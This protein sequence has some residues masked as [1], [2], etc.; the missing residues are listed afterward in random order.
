MYE[1]QID[2]AF[3]FYKNKRHKILIVFND[4]KS[5]HNKIELFNQIVYM[6]I[7]TKK[8]KETVRS[9]SINYIIESAGLDWQK[10]T[11]TLKIH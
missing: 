6:M 7:W 10:K 2:F 11:K 4:V 3:I 8:N 9:S 5:G 1:F